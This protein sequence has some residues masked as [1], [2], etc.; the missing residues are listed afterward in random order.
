MISPILNCNLIFQ[1][2]GYPCQKK[3]C[4]VWVQLWHKRL[5]FSFSIFSLPSLCL[6]FGPISVKLPIKKW[7]LARKQKK[8]HLALLIKLHFFVPVSR[9][10][11]IF[12]A[13][14]SLLVTR[15]WEKEKAVQKPGPKGTPL[16]IYA[17]YSI[18]D[19][20][21]NVRSIL[22]P[23]SLSLPSR[24]AKILWETAFRVPH[25]LIVILYC[26][27]QYLISYTK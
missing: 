7:E 16:R 19:K 25:L 2:F 23:L 24:G 10:V 13:I 21:E 9:F 6:I 8:Q 1:S 14:T 27:L 11:T 15:A 5:L 17:L 18:R 22:H 20:K 3:S 4:A 26:T 12:L